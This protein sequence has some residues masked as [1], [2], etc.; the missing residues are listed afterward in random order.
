MPLFIAISICVAPPE[1]VYRLLQQAQA[2]TA[3]YGKIGQEDIN[4]GQGTDADTYSVSTGPSTTIT[5]T[6]LPSPLANMASVIKGRWYVSASGVSDHG[7]ASVVGSLAWV[8]AQIGASVRE[9]EIPPGTIAI[10]TPFVQSA[11]VTLSFQKGAII[12]DG[13]AITFK[14]GQ[15]LYSSN[16]TSLPA[17][18]SIIGAQKVTLVI[19]QPE[20]LAA[21]LS[22]ASNTYLV[23]EGPGCTI[24]QSGHAVTIAGSFLA[25]KWQVF[26]G[27]GAVTFPH[28]HKVRSSWFADLPTANTKLGAVAKV[29]LV[30]DKAETLSAPLATTSNIAIESDAPGNLITHGA[31]AVDIAGS[32]THVPWDVF[33]GA[34][35]ITVPDAPEVQVF[36][37]SGTWTKPPGAKIVIAEAVGGGGG[38]GAGRQSSSS[39]V[40]KGGAGGGGGSKGVRI[41]NA[42]DITDTVTITVGAG[43]AGG[44]NTAGSNGGESSFGSYL[45]GYAGGGGAV[46]AESPNNVAGGGGASSM[47]NANLAVGGIPASASATAGGFG[48]TGPANIAGISAEYGGG[49]GAGSMNDPSPATDLSGYSGGN[50]RFGSGGG[51]SGAG[52]FPVGSDSFAGGA[53]GGTGPD[54]STGGTPSIAGAGGN[55]TAGNSWRCGGG[56]AGGGTNTTAAGFS[57]GNGGAPG[58][59]G[60]GGGA[61]NAASGSGSGGSGARGEVRVYTFF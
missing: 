4:W 32:L 51:G 23:S 41:F 30:I 35:A 11:N 33:S 18:A 43:G 47:A 49:S 28:G 38:G 46:G 45:K 52:A 34:G 21:P 26:S 8:Q 55:G 10:T 54:N 56:G 57:G 14:H 6:R 48:T 31:H 13:A 20:T 16:F 44:V 12:S 25:G 37:A 39:A 2:T 27:T 50:S 59:G 1:Y 9:I 40:K 17:A 19:D 42:D 3:Y 61:V 7:N 5:L 22:T 15:L 29:K 60:G 24:T 53:G 58:G 36:T